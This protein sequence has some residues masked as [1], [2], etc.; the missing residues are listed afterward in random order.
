MKIKEK[1]HYGLLFFLTTFLLIA[2]SVTSF[3]VKK[4]IRTW[5]NFLY[6][7][8]FTPPNKTFS[9]VWTILYILLGVSGWLIWKNKSFPK[10]FF[11]KVLY[12]I[13][14]ALNLTWSILFFQF[15]LISISLAS[16]IIMIMTTVLMMIFSYKKINHLTLL[17]TPYLLWLGFAGYLNFYAFYFN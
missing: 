6:L 10:L 13:Q 4:N 1:H 17:L 2:G 11:I 7:S 8:R 12:T 14:I 16:I 9:I 5:Y 3:L 15:H